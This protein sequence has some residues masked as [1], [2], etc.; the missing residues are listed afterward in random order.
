M[1]S[2]GKK[3]IALLLVALVAL[4][5]LFGLWGPVVTGMGWVIA[6]IINSFIA[7]LALYLLNFIGLHIPI[8][9]ITILVV[10]LGLFGLALLALLAFFEVYGHEH[11]TA[12]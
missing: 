1:Y 2:Y 12:G 11:I 10:V 6:I 3:N 4:A 8:N 9:L 5:L 7:L